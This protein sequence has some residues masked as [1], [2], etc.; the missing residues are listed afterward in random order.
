M[1]I[2]F[3]GIQNILKERKRKHGR[4]VIMLNKSQFIELN[5]LFG[6]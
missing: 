6:R 4:E 3:I 2:I 5:F 1:P